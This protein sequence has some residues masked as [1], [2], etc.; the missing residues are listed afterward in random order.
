M[1][2]KVF[3]K[4]ANESYDKYIEKKLIFVNSNEK[5]SKNTKELYLKFF[6][7]YTHPLEVAK[8]KDLYDF[9]RMEI[10]HLIKSAPTTSKR[11]KKSLFSAIN[12]Y[13]NWACDRGFNQVGNPCDTIKVTEI[14]DLNEK[15]LRESYYDLDFIYKYIE[16]AHNTRSI[17]GVSS[18]ELIIL[19]LLRYGLT[20]DE[21]IELKKSDVDS[22]NLCLNIYNEQGVKT[23]PID[24]M[25]LHWT[26]TLLE[27]TEFY[28]I[29]RK[30]T[31]Y[32]ISYTPSEYLLKNTSE[33]KANQPCVK[34][35]VYSRYDKMF[36]KIDSIVSDDEK[37]KELKN[38]RTTK[39]SL[40]DLQR[41]RKI[42][43]LLERFENK[44]YIGV[45]DCEEVLKIFTLKTTYGKVYNLR[46]DFELITEIKVRAKL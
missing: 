41:S 13:I 10:I 18:Q 3:G 30:R 36:K 5:Y 1:A 9:D 28:K 40:G 4:Y 43:L 27:E 34:S 29:G 11:T 46:D 12:S 25:F 8:R 6:D 17:T 33:D 32:K 20:M 24:N 21:S 31:T 42:D 37:I 38:M 15:A 7:N 26:D 16:L 22:D 39:I 35:A 2:E 14:L 44:G 19:L 45:E 23:L